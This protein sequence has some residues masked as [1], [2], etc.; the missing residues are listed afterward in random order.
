MT[1]CTINCK[2]YES[3]ILINMIRANEF[4]HTTAIHYIHNVTLGLHTNDVKQTRF[5]WQINSN[6]LWVNNKKD[7]WIPKASSQ[8]ASG[9]R[10]IMV[11]YLMGWHWTGK[12][13]PQKQLRTGSD[14]VRMNHGCRMNQR[15]GY[16]I[17]LVRV[18]T[19]QT[20]K[21]PILFQIF[22]TTVKLRNMHI[23]I[24]ESPSTRFSYVWFCT[25]FK[26][27]MI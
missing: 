10:K 22:C 3:R 2:R 5:I 23:N 9:N 24:S 21:I 6:W 1:S 4:T 12:T 15:E 19:F 11:K 16:I 18:A 17:S 13:M 7:N 25:T 20:D 27:H 14:G 26:H 8:M